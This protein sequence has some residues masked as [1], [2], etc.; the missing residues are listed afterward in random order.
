MTQV[1]DTMSIK[2]STLASGTKVSD[3]RHLHL[4]GCQG[5]SNSDRQCFPD[6]LRPSQSCLVFIPVVPTPTLRVGKA[7]VNMLVAQIRK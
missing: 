5:G 3:G 1:W 7:R 4:G 2:K 6:V